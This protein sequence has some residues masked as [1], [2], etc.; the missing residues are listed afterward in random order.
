MMYFVVKPGTHFCLYRDHFH[1]DA[2]YQTNIYDS[3]C[4]TP[5]LLGGPDL[6][7][8]QISNL[9]RSLRLA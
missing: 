2:M 7:S 1:D 5:D 9:L 6:R 8:I 3:E 4:I